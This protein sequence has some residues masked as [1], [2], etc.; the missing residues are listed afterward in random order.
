[1][2]DKTKIMDPSIVLDDIVTEILIS[3]D[4]ELRETLNDAG[5]DTEQMVA[6]G[7]AVAESVLANSRKAAIDS[8]PDDVPTDPAKVKALFDRLLGLPGVSR[9][10]FT[11]AF[12]DADEQSDR[13]MR[14]LTE[15]LLQ[16]VKRQHDEG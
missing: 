5:L 1:M 8:L 4:A 12:R 13:D 2:T 6:Q 14:L 15:N 11:M 10:S 7:R 9:D 3:S 16:L